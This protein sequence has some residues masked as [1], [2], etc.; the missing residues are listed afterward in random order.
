MGR[1]LIDS[2]LIHVTLALAFLFSLAPTL[3]AHSTDE[4]YIWLNPVDDHYSGEVQIRLP[5]LRKYLELEIPE[6]LEGA[7]SALQ[8]HA[9]VLEEYVRQHFEIKTLAGEAVQYLSLIHI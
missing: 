8:G 1:V 2:R 7:K 9:V 3:S 6:D 5:D 4:T